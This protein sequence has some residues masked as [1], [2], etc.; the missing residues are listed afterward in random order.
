MK[1]VF[2]A[3]VIGLL[4]SGAHAQ[5]ADV[6]AQGSPIMSLLPLVAI[7]FVFFFLVIRPQMRQAKQRQAALD[8]LK[9]GDMVVTGGGVIGKITKLHDDHAHVEIAAGVEV[10]L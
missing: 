3:L 8:A 9:K 4:A 6:P 5:A 1:T 2:S 10:K 7:F